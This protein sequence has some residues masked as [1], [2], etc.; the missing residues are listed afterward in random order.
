MLSKMNF[1]DDEPLWKR[2]PSISLKMDHIY[3]A[4]TSDR[5]NTVFY[6]HFTPENIDPI[7]GK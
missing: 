5:R 1:D 6:M 2:P 3:G 7:A 4:E